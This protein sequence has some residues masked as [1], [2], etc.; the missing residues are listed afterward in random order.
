VVPMPDDEPEVLPVPA[1]PHAVSTRAH[2]KGMVHF[3]IR[4]LLKNKSV[5]HK[6]HSCQ[7]GTYASE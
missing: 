5:K 3:I 1:V 7:N 6:T 4:I 2:A